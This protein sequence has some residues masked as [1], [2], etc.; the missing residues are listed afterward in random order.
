M[1]VTTG[2]CYFPTYCDAFSY[3]SANIYGNQSEACAEGIAYKLKNG[4]IHIGKPPLKEGEELKII[5][6][7]YHICQ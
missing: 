6:N 1:K 4:E 5:D 2:T 3:Y 7:R